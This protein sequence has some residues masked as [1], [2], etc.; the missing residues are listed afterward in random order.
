MKR[1]LKNKQS[2]NTSKHLVIGEKRPKVMDTFVPFVTF[3]LFKIINDLIQA[4]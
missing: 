3:S 2:A 4:V 1:N